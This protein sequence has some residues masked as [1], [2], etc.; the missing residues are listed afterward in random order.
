MKAHRTITEQRGASAVEFALVLPLL[1]LLV[2]GIVEWGMYMFNKHIITN[3]SRTGARRGIV[4]EIPRVP[5]S[6]IQQTVVNYTSTHLVTFGT[7]NAPVTTVPAIC[8]KFDDDLAVT[9]SYDYTF[10]LLPTLSAGRV[11]PSK[12]ITARTVMKCE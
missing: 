10:L 6:E 12:T 3:A 11:S 5:L 8:T 2:F 9:V 7:P 1:L 4:Q